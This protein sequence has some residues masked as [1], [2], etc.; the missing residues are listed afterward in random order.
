M[1]YDFIF[2][3]VLTSENSDT[4]V[5]ITMKLFATD[6]ESAIDEIDRLQYW[7]DTW[8]TITG[9]EVSN[10]KCSDRQIDCTGSF[11]T[12]FSRLK[13]DVRKE[14]FPLTKSMMYN[15][16]N[17]WLVRKMEQVMFLSELKVS[18]YES[19]KRKLEPKYGEFWETSCFISTPYLCHA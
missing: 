7:E 3:G 14:M 8:K 10:V 9:E 12:L 13:D 4:K 17:A 6:Y 16:Q 19:I 18:D 11:T 15:S 2:R 5:P 1:Y